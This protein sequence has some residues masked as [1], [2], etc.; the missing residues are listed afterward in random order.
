MLSRPRYEVTGEIEPFDERDNV[1]ARGQLRPGSADCTE[2]YTRRPEREAGDGE[3]RAI[4]EF[5]VSELDHPFFPEEIVTVMKGGEEDLVDGPLSP[6][7][8][9]ISP[10]R[11]T[12]KLKGFG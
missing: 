1:Q 7:R 11:A 2:F 12:E 5:A 6:T 4:P 9:G 8:A 10:E 3:I